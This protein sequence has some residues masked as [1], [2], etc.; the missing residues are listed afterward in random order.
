MPRLW[1]PRGSF[2]L[3]PEF[4]LELVVVEDRNGLVSSEVWGDSIR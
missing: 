2:E 4:V 1:Q 3:V